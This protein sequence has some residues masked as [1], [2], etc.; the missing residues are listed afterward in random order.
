MQNIRNY[1]GTHMIERV[2][3]SNNYSGAVMSFFILEFEPSIHGCEFVEKTTWNRMR[4][5]QNL[6]LAKI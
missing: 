3:T 1:S 5:N 4:T 2:R 6:N